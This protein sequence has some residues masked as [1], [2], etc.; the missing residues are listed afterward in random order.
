MGRQRITK[1]APVQQQMI[2]LRVQFLPR[3]LQRTLIPDLQVVICL[4]TRTRRRFKV[5]LGASMDAGEGA[6]SDGLAD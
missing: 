5:K 2:D 1:P 6:D 4:E 3:P